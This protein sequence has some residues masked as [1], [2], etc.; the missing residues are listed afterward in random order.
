MKKKLL[1][2]G[3]GLMALSA[4]GQIGGKLAK[5]V[6]DNKF[7]NVDETLVQDMEFY[8]DGNLSKTVN[9]LMVV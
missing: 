9:G 2:M 5:K 8:L 3:L 7:N 6:I 1:I 4:F